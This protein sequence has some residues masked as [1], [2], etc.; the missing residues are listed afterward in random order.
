[1]EKTRFRKILEAKGLKPVS[2]AA[3]GFPYGTVIAHYYGAREMSLSTAKRYATVLKIPL[4]E[5]LGEP[6]PA[7]DKA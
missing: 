1:M 3:L 6:S 2:V 5:L 7:Q 4:W